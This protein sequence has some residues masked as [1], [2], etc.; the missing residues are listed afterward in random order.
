MIYKAGLATL[1]VDEAKGA[2]TSSV[3]TVKGTAERGYPLYR[4]RLRG[5]EGIASRMSGGD[6]AEATPRTRRAKCE[7]AAL[8]KSRR[9][10]R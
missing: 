9:L 3:T 8:W 6:A 7:E 2:L 10:L 5:E 4:H 1:L